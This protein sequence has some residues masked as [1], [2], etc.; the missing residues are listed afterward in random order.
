MVVVYNEAFARPRRIEASVQLKASPAEYVNLSLACSC[1]VRCRSCTHL[2]QET[3]CSL[4]S[5]TAT[6]AIHRK[7]TGYI[8]G[9]AVGHIFGVVKAVQ[10]YVV[11]LERSGQ[12]Y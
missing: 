3:A 1:H 11:V 7:C 6:K 5:G 10:Q 8:L 9:E 12:P 2:S 4:S